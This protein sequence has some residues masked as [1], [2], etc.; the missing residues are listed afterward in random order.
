MFAHTSGADDA[1]HEEIVAASP[2]PCLCA[3]AP[4]SPPVHVR[5]VTSM[6]R[7]VTSAC[8]CAP[9]IDDA[10]H[11]YACAPSID[12]ASHAYA[13]M[14]GIETITTPDSRGESPTSGGDGPRVGGADSWE[15]LDAG[16]RGRRVVCVRPCAHVIM[17]RVCMHARC[18]RLSVCAS[19]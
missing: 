15:N 19:A 1:F 3:R 8:A 7:C 2:A 4:P 5:A 14:P 16:A 13:C 9:S 17:V 10:S 11:A 12:D 18:C 6:Q